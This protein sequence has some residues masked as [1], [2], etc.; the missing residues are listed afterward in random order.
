MEAA[1]VSKCANPSCSATFRYLREGKIF[2]IAH[3]PGA[4]EIASNRRASTHERFWLCGECARKMTLISH[5]AGILVVPLPDLSE[6]QK[7]Q[8]NGSVAIGSNHESS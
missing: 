8:Q 3:R 4:A 2:H 5:A 1:M 6:T 7:Q